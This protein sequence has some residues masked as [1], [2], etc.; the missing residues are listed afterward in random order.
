[1]SRAFAVVGAFVVSGIVMV[2]CAFAWVFIYSTLIDTSGDDAYYQEYA[3]VASPVVALVVAGPIFFAVGRF[4]RR[5]GERAVPL[6]LSVV[7]LNLILDVVAVSTMAKDVPYN[8]SMSAVVALV[9]LGAAY[10]GAR[11]VAPA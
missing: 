6:A 11:G 9:K 4:M 1:M 5:F 2:A 8:A 10:F 7:L 3:K